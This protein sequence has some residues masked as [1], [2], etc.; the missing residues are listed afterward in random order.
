MNR[1][2]K[3]HT[4]G[5]RNGLEKA[6]LS[7]RLA[8]TLPSSRSII[9]RGETLEWVPFAAAEVKKIV[10]MPKKKTLY[11]YSGLKTRT[12]QKDNSL[13]DFSVYTIVRHKN[14][15]GEKD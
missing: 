11:S 10:R 1:L 6:A 9:S 2:T 4:T 15:K 3:I 7:I 13:M 5:P 8:G 14:R 12:N